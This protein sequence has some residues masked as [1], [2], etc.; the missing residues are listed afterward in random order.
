MYS[1]ITITKGVA[2]RGA[3]DAIAPLERSEKQQLFPK[4][5]K[6]F[7]PAWAGLRPASTTFLV[8]IHVI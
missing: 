4:K 6:I 1:S 5:C 2:G 8:S 7:L 3:K